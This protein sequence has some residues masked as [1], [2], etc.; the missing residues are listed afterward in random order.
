MALNPGD[1]R[2]DGGEGERQLPI[3]Y[4]LPKTDDPN[5]PPPGDQHRWCFGCLRWVF[6]TQYRK[7]SESCKQCLR[8]TCAKCGKSF[9]DVSHLNRHDRQVHQGLKPYRCPNCDY[10]TA[11][12]CNLKV[13]VCRTDG[14]Q[15][16][17]HTMTEIKHQRAL[18]IETGG[19]MVKT[20]H[21]IIDIL[22]DTELIEI[23]NYAHWLTAVG[24]LMVY[25]LT[26]PDR[27]KR[28]HFFGQRPTDAKL[29]S[30]LD[31]MKQLNIRVTMEQDINPPV[32]EHVPN[33]A[34]GV[35]APA[36]TEPI[37]APIPRRPPRQ[38]VTPSA[39]VQVPECKHLLPNVEKPDGDK[40]RGETVQDSCPPT[41]CSPVSTADTWERAFDN[42]TDVSRPKEERHRQQPEAP[43]R[44]AE[45][46][47]VRGR[48]SCDG[49]VCDKNDR[50][51][52]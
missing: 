30:I 19:R 7:S 38:R 39:P 12:R 11:E 25:G 34:G 6:H 23:K 20:P 31:A 5:N 35:P 43:P 13:H 2:R 32:N 51:A 41:V 44:C 50:S 17:G 37:I 3:V 18:E 45:A 4:D 1:A 21:G 52:G 16:V 26:Y 29:N 40:P 46:S 28:V 47:D 8:V 48:R 10:A 49:D 33:T 42:L 9:S 22:T 27:A 36:V 15:L 14:S 24:Q